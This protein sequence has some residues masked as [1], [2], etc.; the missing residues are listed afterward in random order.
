MFPTKN[1]FCLQVLTVFICIAVI[2]MDSA[3]VQSQSHFSITFEDGHPFPETLTPDSTSTVH[4]QCEMHGISSAESSQQ[5]SASSISQSIHLDEL[6]STNIFCNQLLWFRLFL[7]ILSSFLLCLSVAYCLSQRIQTK[8]DIVTMCPEPKSI[9]EIWAHSYQSFLAN[10]MI[11]DEESQQGITSDPCWSTHRIEI[12]TETLWYSN[13]Y[14]HEWKDGV[15][16]KSIL[17]GAVSVYCFGI[18]TFSLYRLISDLI[19][20]HRRTLHEKSNGFKKYLENKKQHK[21]TNKVHEDKKPS[22]MQQIMTFYFKLCGAD[23]TGWILSKFVSEITE[24]LLQ[25]N[26]LLL[27]NGY[28]IMDPQEQH[29]AEK[30][31]AIITFAAVLSFNLI[32]SGLLWMNY[33]IFPSYCFGLRFKRLIFFVDKFSDLLYTLFPFYVV[34]SDEYCKNTDDILVLL[35]PLATASWWVFTASF[36]PLFVL[37]NICLMISFSTTERMRIDYFNRW[38]LNEALSPRVT[39]NAMFGEVRE[40]GFEFSKSIDEGGNSVAVGIQRIKKELLVR[41][42]LYQTSEWHQNSNWTSLFGD[43]GCVNVHCCWSFGIGFVSRSH[44]KLNPR[45]WIGCRLQ[46]VIQSIHHN[47]NK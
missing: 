40:A 30:P 9:E 37:C 18:L 11:M 21:I 8:L 7:L 36:L 27:Y 38:R 19:D 4:P 35:G 12:N 13:K 20:V 10:D 32:C 41:Q 29:L 31:N 1:A 3:R 43:I 6:V 5:G 42:K 45:L 34:L 24:F 23:T 44:R 16:G 26:A 33:A 39:T 46:L 17:F 15:D 2:F 22:R 25:S 28:N 14:V 47:N